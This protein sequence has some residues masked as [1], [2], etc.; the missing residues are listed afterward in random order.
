MEIDKT[1]SKI[2]PQLNVYARNGNLEDCK[3]LI[4]ESADVNCEVIFKI[5]E[6]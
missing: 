2:T 3:K 5:P 1:S 6:K 4:E